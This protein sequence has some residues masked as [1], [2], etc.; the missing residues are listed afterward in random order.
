MGKRCY[1]LNGSKAKIRKGFK[2]PGIYSQ[3]KTLTNPNYVG[4][5][6]E[7][8]ESSSSARIDSIGLL[9]EYEYLREE[10][11]SAEAKF[12]ESFFK[13]LDGFKNTIPEYWVKNCKERHKE[14][15]SIFTKVVEQP[16]EVNLAIVTKSGKVYTLDQVV[17]AP[18]HFEI[19]GV[20]EDE[21][22]I[23]VYVSQQIPKIY[24][25]LNVAMLHVSLAC[26]QTRDSQP[27][28]FANLK[29]LAFSLYERGG[30]Y[31][32]TNP[33][34]VTWRAQ[35]DETLKILTNEPTRQ[36]DDEIYQTFKDVLLDILEGKEAL[37][38]RD[39][40]S[41][42]NYVKEIVTALVA[43]ERYCSSP[44]NIG[45][46]YFSMAS[47][48]TDI[49]E[50]Y[51]RGINQ[52]LLKSALES[53][54]LKDCE[55]DK[56]TGYISHYNVYEN[57]KEE[58]WV[59][60]IHIPNPGKFKTRAIH[61]ST[62][63]IQDRCSYIHNRLYSVLQRIPSDCTKDQTRG[64]S[65][66]L[67]V[68][69]P[70]WREDRLYPSVLAY[71][72]S[73]ATDRLWSWF[74]ER[75]LRLV[76]DEVIVDFWHTI[77]TCKK[78]F[79]FKD[80]TVKEYQQINGQPQGLL[81]SFDA[82]AL[83]H[84]IIMLMTM[85]LSHRED[86]L[87]SQFYRV[88]GD[89]SIISSVRRDRENLVGK[90]YCRICQWVNTPI[91]KEKSTEIL[92]DNQVALVEFAKVYAL[93]GDYFSPIPERLANRIGM[94]NK[95][96]YAFSSAFW[97]QRHGMDNRQ[98]IENLI[99]RYYSEEDVPIAKALMFSGIIPSYAE[100]G[101]I[102]PTAMAEDLTY[103][104]GLSYWYNKIKATF[105]LN[106][107]SD[108]AKE[109]LAF[110]DKELKDGL[111]ELIP[112][113][114]TF[115]FDAI[116]DPDHK[117][118]VAIQDNLDKEATIKELIHCS[119]DQAGVIAVVTKLTESEVN[120]IRSV[121]TMIDQL[122]EEPARLG[123][124]RDTIRDLG[125]MLSPLDRLNYRSVYKRDAL[126]IIIFRSTIETYKILFSSEGHLN[127]DT[128]RGTPT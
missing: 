119:D 9:G 51:K 6:Q 11:K 19:K 29:H 65:F 50:L 35:E 36:E 104:L 101:F 121:I 97:G 7:V 47:D 105:A 63:A 58:P 81:G 91:N 31:N 48:C 123:F 93:N 127:S 95:D 14:L 90:S 8:V 2:G 52:S 62:S 10:V 80:G 82:F 112:E 83:A 75:C 42:K 114:L 126:S 34:P 60:T 99:K 113:D 94:H 111:A 56:Y 23:D 117:L 86:L 41:I 59:V 49:P 1:E 109:T 67:Q 69:N 92:C 106:M 38:R 37:K 30:L 107:L 40:K 20:T 45:D 84:H 108:K 21:E 17:Y 85:K 102:D 79:K 100:M 98:W 53:D 24:A 88:L 44:Y 76:F 3:G 110:E 78:L 103:Q 96:Y 54:P 70:I 25:S 120:A 43:T 22:I 68:T 66:L 4:P 122:A 16:E 72:W 57:Q 27:Y 39:R 64:I 5:K 55:F 124:Y 18:K 74:Q 12:I 73:N 33:D 46:Y 13:D 128:E 61:L 28:L 89:D 15:F 77:S 71:D 118:M 116:Q 87:G 115:L 32:E 26:Q 125:T